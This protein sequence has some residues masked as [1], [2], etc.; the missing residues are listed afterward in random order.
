MRIITLKRGP[1]VVRENNPETIRQALQE[2][3]N[4][5]PKKV[6]KRR[7]NRRRWNYQYYVQP[8]EKE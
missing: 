7:K 4:H 8:G 6:W 2:G 5:V 3:F 1:V